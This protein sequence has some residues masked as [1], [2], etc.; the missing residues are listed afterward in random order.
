M[1]KLDVWL[2]VHLVLMI[3]KHVNNVLMDIFLLIKF[4]KNVNKIVNHVILIFYLLAKL[5]KWD[6][7]LH[8]RVNVLNAHHKIV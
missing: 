4:V 6:M 8:N 1:E 5:V 3:T 7:H 2:V